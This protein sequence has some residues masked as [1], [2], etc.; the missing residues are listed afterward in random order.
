LHKK[1]LLELSRDEKEIQI[2]P[3]GSAEAAEIIRRKE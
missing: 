3:P 2:L 1:R